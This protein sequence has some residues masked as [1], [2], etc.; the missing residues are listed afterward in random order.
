MVLKRSTSFAEP[1]QSGVRWSMPVITVSSTEPAAGNMTA[2]PSNRHG[3]AQFSAFTRRKRATST[4]MRAAAASKQH[5]PQKRRFCVNITYPRCSRQSRCPRP[6]PPAWRRVPPDTT[7]MA[8]IASITQRQSASHRHACTHGHEE[9]MPHGAC[10]SFAASSW[11]P[12]WL[13]LG[14]CGVAWVDGA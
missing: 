4:Y 13:C 6:L 8:S 14:R 10:G 11:R 3:I 2:T 5:P 1:M 12:K 7:D 9:E